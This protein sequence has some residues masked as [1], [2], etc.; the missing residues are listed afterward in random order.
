M[1]DLPMP[2][3][4]LKLT[5]EWRP[6]AE[7][8][9][10][11]GHQES[12]TY[13]M[14]LARGSMDRAAAYCLTQD[15][16]DLRAFVVKTPAL[17]S[18]LA[19]V[20]R[21]GGF[22]PRVLDMRGNGAMRVESMLARTALLWGQAH[23]ENAG[24]N[25][26]ELS[27]GLS[28]RLMHTELRG[29][30]SEDLRLP[31]GAIYIRVPQSTG[32]RVWDRPVVGIYV[33][34]HNEGAHGRA[35]SMLVHGPGMIPGVSASQGTCSL[36]TFP[37]ALLPEMPLSDAPLITDQLS[38]RGEINRIGDPDSPNQKVG[39]EIWPWVQNVVLYLTM[40]DAMVEE[41]EANEEAASLRARIA[42]L[43]PGSKRD[44]LKE[45]LRG[46]VLDR[47]IYLGRGLPYEGRDLAIPG[48]RRMPDY[49]VRVTGHWKNQAHGPGRVDRKR[50]WVQP[51]F[52]N[53]E[54]LAPATGTTTRV[55]GG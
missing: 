35:W 22:D 3:E 31:F 6:I 25:L 18:Y 15:I 24:S 41:R 38:Q 19:D 34:E 52:R 36:Y 51:Y 7:R 47:R 11:D 37:I 20:E 17:N 2:R 49:V 55:V 26:Y 29:L 48:G 23:L 27:D 32:F 50:I 53:L 33:I 42:K 4:I 54:A 16:L 10:A 21:R 43:A 30:H 45:R 44:R 9:I 14:A 46:E 28:D 13:S 12:L 39:Q 1:S 8:M 40:P 5:R